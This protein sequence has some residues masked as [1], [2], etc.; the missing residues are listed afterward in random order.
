MTPMDR[1]WT[2][3]E[4]L[5][6]G[7]LLAGLSPMVIAAACGDDGP[8]GTTGSTGATGAASGPS[9]SEAL[10]GPLNV[11]AWD[12]YDNPE[13]VQGFKDLTGVDIN[14]KYHGGDP[15]LV[16]LLRADPEGWDVVNPDNDWVGRL[17]ELDLIQPIDL[18]EYPHVQEDYEPFRNFEPFT[19]DGQSFAVPTRFGINGFIYDTNAVTAEQASDALFIWEQAFAGNVSMVDWFDL[20]IGLV[21]LYLGNTSPESMTQAQLDEVTDKLIELKPNITAIHADRSDIQADLTSGES[22]VGWGG[23]TSDMATALKVDGAPVEVSI[24]DQGALI[25]TEGLCITKGTQH[26]ATA[27]AY[28]DYMT[29]AEVLAKMAWNDVLQIQVVNPKVED[30]LEPEQFAALGLEE[31]TQW[32]ANPN[33]ILQRQAP[34]VDAWGAAWERFKSA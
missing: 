29:S 28:L 20:Y 26:L 31:A 21:G 4:L 19:V 10:T 7:A 16:S 2:R 9:P 32:F 22:T 11:L 15:K 6:R 33:V 25:W 14:Y 12:G 1:R 27:K 24:P 18:A 5:R 23:G 13:V 34:D 3:R 30:Y 17:V 8:G